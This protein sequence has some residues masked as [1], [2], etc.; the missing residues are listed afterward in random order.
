MDD[1]ALFQVDARESIMLKKN[2]VFM[3]VI[4]KLRIEYSRQD[5][6]GRKVLLVS[7]ILGLESGV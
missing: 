7:T 2:A 3:Q 1:G 6:I 4:Q 5:S